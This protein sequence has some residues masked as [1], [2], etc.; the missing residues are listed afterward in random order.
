MLKMKKSYNKARKGNSDVNE[1]GFSANE[2]LR[3]LGGN[4]FVAMTGANN[5]MKDDKN[6]SLIFKVPNAGKG[7]KWVEIRL[8]QMDTYDMRFLKRDKQT[9][10]KE[11]KGV[12]ADQLQS[13]FTEQTGLDTHL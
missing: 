8:T 11:Y 2:V 13:L 5:F 3:Q 7:I 4:K 9:V 1:S 6:R 12:Y 10:V